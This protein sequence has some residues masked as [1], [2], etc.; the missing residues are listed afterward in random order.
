M[1]PCWWYGACNLAQVGWGYDSR[2]GSKFVVFCILKCLANF[3]KLKH[4]GY[5][6]TFGKG[7]GMIFM[8]FHRGI[9]APSGVRQVF[10]HGWTIGVYADN[11]RPTDF[12][13]V[14]F[15]EFLMKNRCSWTKCFLACTRWYARYKKYNELLYSY[16]TLFFPQLL[17]L[18][19]ARF[20]CK[21]FSLGL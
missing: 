15:T 6:S 20:S 12:F 9:F 8:S 19:F 11:V 17:G 13:T 5:H 4:S 3:F 2:R 14:L 16:S 21:K 1:C 7:L 10:H 18:G